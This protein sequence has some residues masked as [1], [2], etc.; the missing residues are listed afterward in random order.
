MILSENLDLFSRVGYST[1]FESF[2]R[3]PSSVENSFFIRVRSLVLVTKYLSENL[4]ESSGLHFQAGLQ[5]R[6]LTFDLF[7]FY[8]YTLASDVVPDAN[9]FSSLNIRLGLGI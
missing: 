9:G 4:I 2:S 7:T 5:L 3:T 6:L 1:Q 8:R